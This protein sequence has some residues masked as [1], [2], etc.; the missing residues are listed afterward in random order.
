MEEAE[1]EAATCP[2]PAARSEVAAAA[3]GNRTEDHS[4]T[5]GPLARGF[6]VANQLVVESSML[7][8]VAFAR[9]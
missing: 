2:E 8:E 3:A 5:E 6:A 9:R 7:S 1:A 4:P